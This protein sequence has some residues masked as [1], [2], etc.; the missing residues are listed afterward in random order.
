MK[1]ETLAALYARRLDFVIDDILVLQLCKSEVL[2]AAARGDI[3]LNRL[4][5]EELAARGLDLKCRW[6][7]FERA[8]R[9][10]DDP[11]PGM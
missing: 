2:A 8:A 7:G 9:A 1:T 11:A 10:I 3:D 4:A 5:R 6:V